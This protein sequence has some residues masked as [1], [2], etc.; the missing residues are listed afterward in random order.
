MR[1]SILKAVVVLMGVAFASSA[2]AVTS[3]SDST[4]IG[5]GTFA[6]SAKVTI[7]VIST[8]TAYAATSQ[9]LIGKKQFG[10][11]NAD[12]KI[13]FNDAVSSGPTAPGGATETL[14]GW[15]TY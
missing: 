15:S 1:K 5:G 6:P 3:I 12:P 14:S 13:Y 8:S 11:N 10:T 9:H 7:K 2:F 4:V